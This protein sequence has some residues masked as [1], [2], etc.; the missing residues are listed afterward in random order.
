MFLDLYMHIQYVYINIY[1]YVFNY[2]VFNTDR[3]HSQFPRFGPWPNASI[4]P[5]PSTCS[6]APC[7]RPTPMWRRWQRRWAPAKWRGNNGRHSSCW[8][9]RSRW[10]LWG[11]WESTGIITKNEDIVV[12]L[13]EYSFNK[14]SEIEYL[15]SAEGHADERFIF[16]AISH[17]IW[18]MGEWHVTAKLCGLL[19]RYVQM[20]VR[21]Q[22]H[23]T[24]CDLC[25]VNGWDLRNGFTDDSHGRENVWNK[26]DYS[27]SLSSDFMKGL[28]APFAAVLC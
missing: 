14:E 16:L 10:A 3:S 25:A 11:C 27:L 13:I 7:R 1:L 24:G 28:Q 23:I 22:T 12:I 5:W 9:W 2:L 26:W 19:S 20:A 21:V 17:I 4:G 8:G 6:T 18:M 15:N